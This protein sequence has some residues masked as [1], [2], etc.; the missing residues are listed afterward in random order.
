VKLLRRPGL[1]PLLVLGLMTQTG[2][3]TR[4]LGMGGEP[5]VEGSKGS[6]TI[7]K[8]ERLIDSFA[9]RDVALIADACEAVKRETPDAAVRRGMQHVKLANGSA[10]YDIITQPQPLGRLADL[11]VLVE[12][13]HLVW[14]EE[15]GAQRRFGNLGYER[16]VPAIEE[17]RRDMARHADLAM[18]PDRR[19]K[20][21]H[22][23]RR[24]R[25][26][27]PNVQFVSG[28]RFGSL[29]EAGSKSIFAS[30]SSFFDVINP[31]DDTSDSVERSRLLADRAFHFS[32]RL[33]KL[34]DWQAEAALDDTIAK[35]EVRAVLDAVDRVS[36]AIEQMPDRVAREREEILKSLD[37]RHADVVSGGLG[38]PRGPRAGRPRDGSRQRIR[39]GV[40]RASRRGRQGSRESAVAA[41]RHPGLHGGRRPISA[42]RAGGREP[43]RAIQV[44]DR[45]RRLEGDRDHAPPLHAARRVPAPPPAPT[46]PG[47][48]DPPPSPADHAGLAD[49]IPVDLINAPR[50]ASDYRAWNA[51]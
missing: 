5:Q 28:I 50:P 16:L 45:L 33:P 11:Y 48:R 19:Q 41:V 23:I 21:D 47:S 42:A 43:R 31:L 14:V 35:P 15:G 12:L 51:C 27:N 13:Q 9:D 24:W 17:I 32:K 46:R 20:F 34:L 8:L 22:L 39:E 25:D 1:L 38:G 3:I 37:D 10:V 26:R 44:A 30:A 4:W 7:T 36:K 40:P 18:K 2:C 6:I 49:L 29:P